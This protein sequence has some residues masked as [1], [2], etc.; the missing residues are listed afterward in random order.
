MAYSTWNS[1]IQ[2]YVY[3]HCSYSTI[4]PYMNYYHQ[5]QKACFTY[6]PSGLKV[7]TPLSYSLLVKYI[8]QNFQFK[9]D[10]FS[11]YTTELFYWC[12]LTTIV[13]PVANCKMS[14]LMKHKHHTCSSWWKE[15]SKK[16]IKKK[17]SASSVQYGFCVRA[18]LLSD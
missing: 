9:N 1:L 16:I 3:L 18:F 7:F 13:L 10:I 12:C 8:A 11:E 4:I 17:I 14:S 15:S 2:E 5:N 6:R